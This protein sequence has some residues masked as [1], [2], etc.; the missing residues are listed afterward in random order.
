M[1]SFSAWKRARAL[2]K[3]RNGQLNVYEQVA[4]LTSSETCH[5]P[6]SSRRSKSCSFRQAG[7][8]PPSGSSVRGSEHRLGPSPD[9]GPA[10]QRVKTQPCCLLKLMGQDEGLTGRSLGYE[11][12]SFLAAP[13]VPAWGEPREVVAVLALELPDL[14]PSPRLLSL[15]LS[16]SH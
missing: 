12:I 5:R 15:S 9:L 4:D 1:K 3:R 14:W 2:K 10:A 6:H 16:L 7:I 8:L 13:E 11:E